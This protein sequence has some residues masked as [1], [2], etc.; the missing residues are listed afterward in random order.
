MPGEV[1][2]FSFRAFPQFILPGNVTGV[3]NNQTILTFSA[4]AGGYIVGGFSNVTAYTSGA[5]ICNLTYTNSL[6][7]LIVVPILFNNGTGAST[8][9][10]QS[11]EEQ[12]VLMSFQTGGVHTISVT[13]DTITNAFIGT[14]NLSAWITKIF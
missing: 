12:M 4:N 5:I 9:L 1:S 8:A 10:Q 7:A 3:T 13:T 2:L 14:Y 11:G 6:S